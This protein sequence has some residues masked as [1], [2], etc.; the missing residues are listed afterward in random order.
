MLLDLISV[1]FGC[2]PIYMVK[3]PG[4]FRITLLLGFVLAGLCWYF[5]SIYTR[6]WNKKFRI[7][8]LHHTFCAFASGCTLLFT[9]LFASLYY[10]KDAALLSIGA[11]QLQLNGDS[12]WGDQT[13]SKAY[14]TVKDLG[15]EDFSNA[16][17]PGSP[18]ALIP[19]NHDESRQIAAATYANE[20][21]KHF[22]RKRPFLSKVVWSSPGVPS[23]VIFQDVKAWHEQNPHYPPSRAIEIA[24][25]QIKEG[26]QPQVPRII[27]LSR[28][29]V[30]TLFVLMQAIPFGLIGWAAHRDIKAQL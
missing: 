29:A 19:T 22:D 27:T 9:I 18:G 8:A 20:A 5:C 2:I 14:D 26:L 21:C 6:L 24:A 11:W 16:P 13:F 15:I 4:S 30:A 17:P 1:L 25:T 3:A 12:T 23:D 28:L 10:T 7:T